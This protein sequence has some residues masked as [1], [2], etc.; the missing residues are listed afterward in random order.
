MDWL[1]ATDCRC[2]ESFAE[3]RSAG[4]I[5]ESRSLAVIDELR[6]QMT[7]ATV[8]TPSRAG[9]RKMQR[10]GFRAPSDL[11]GLRFLIWPQISTLIFK[12]FFTVFSWNLVIVRN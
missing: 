8:R 10:L 2:I 11:S 4:L 6:R 9:A 5:A 12:T 1:A 7:D 3:R